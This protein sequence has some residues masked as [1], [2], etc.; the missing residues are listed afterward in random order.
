MGTPPESAWVVIWI[1]EHREGPR[2]LRR[3]RDGRDVTEM[4]LKSTPFARVH[5]RGGEVGDR[6]NAVSEL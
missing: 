5:C 6:Q 4:R 2:H 1:R 3:R